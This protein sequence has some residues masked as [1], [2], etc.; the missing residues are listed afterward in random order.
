ML[1]S[2]NDKSSLLEQTTSCFNLLKSGRHLF[3][4]MVRIRGGDEMDV[5]KVKSTLRRGAQFGQYICTTSS[6]KKSVNKSCKCNCV[7]TGDFVTGI[8]KSSNS[9]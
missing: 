8:D 5:L 1:L 6:F 3:K 2:S 7:V 4:T 9:S